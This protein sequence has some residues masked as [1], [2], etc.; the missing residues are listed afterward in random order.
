[1]RTCIA[2]AG[3]AALLALASCSNENP[4]APR[5]TGVATPTAR[6]QAV[7]VAQCSSCHG[8]DLR[9]GITAAPSL[10]AVK[11]YT[12]TQF[13][14]LLCTGLTEDHTYTQRAM[15]PTLTPNDKIALYNYLS[16]YAW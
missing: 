16:G 14:Q 1:M 10:A 11:Q 13:D 2:L 4:A 6:G 8:P 15:A 5:G 12:F 3:A 7:A 9:G